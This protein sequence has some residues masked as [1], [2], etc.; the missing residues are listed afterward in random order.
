[1]SFLTNLNFEELLESVD[2]AKNLRAEV[3]TAEDFAILL[4]MIIKKN[5]EK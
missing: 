1:M 2:I 4:K 3:L 5:D